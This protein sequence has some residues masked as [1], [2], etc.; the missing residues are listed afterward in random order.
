MRKGKQDGKTAANDKIKIHPKFRTDVETKAVLKALSKALDADS[1]CN[2]S[3]FSEMVF[4]T[5]AL[6]K[7]I[8][9]E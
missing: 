6:L 1:N 2:Y 5:K 4:R 8:T 3:E 9:E 7:I